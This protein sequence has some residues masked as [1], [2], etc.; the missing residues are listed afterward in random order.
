MI[1][2]INSLWNTNQRLPDIGNFLPFPRTHI[3]LELHV[4]LLLTFRMI[5]QFSFCTFITSNAQRSL[6]KTSV[7]G[8]DCKGWSLACSY[9][10]SQVRQSWNYKGKNLYT[11]AP[12]WLIHSP[13]C[14]TTQVQPLTKCKINYGDVGIAWRFILPDF[15]CGMQRTQT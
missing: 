15:T 11:G 8:L 9:R 7:S 2:K 12:T 5:A 14:T 3:E 4:E 13:Q 1:R 10:Q 6:K